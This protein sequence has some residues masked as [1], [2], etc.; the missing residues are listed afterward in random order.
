MSREIITPKIGEVFEFEGRKAKCLKDRP[1]TER[2]CKLCCFLRSGLCHKLNCVGKG[3]FDGKD[4][5]FRKV[6]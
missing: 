5:H 3:R 6:K 1:T 4:V 2:P